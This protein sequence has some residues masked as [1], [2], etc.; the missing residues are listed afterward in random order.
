MHAICAPFNAAV[1]YLIISLT[2]TNMEQRQKYKIIGNSDQKVIFY[3]LPKS[4]TVVLE[5]EKSYSVSLY[6]CLPFSC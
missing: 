5:D 6:L 4:N 3:F 2:Y 1:P